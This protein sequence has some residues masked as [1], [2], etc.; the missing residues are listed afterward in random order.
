MNKFKGIYQLTWYR[1]QMLFHNMA[2]LLRRFHNAGIQTMIIK[3]AALTLLYYRDYGLR[4]M[5]DFDVLIHTKQATAAI[6]LLKKLGW[7]SKIKLDTA[8]QWT[9][10]WYKQYEQKKDLRKFTEQQIDNYIYLP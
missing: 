2:I 7:S 9:S 5:K 3:G 8:L 1:N 10:D 6:N 4:P